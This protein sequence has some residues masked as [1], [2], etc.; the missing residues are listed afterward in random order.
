MEIG[1]WRMVK[2]GKREENPNAEAQR[3]HGEE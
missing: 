2:S 1:K 3:K